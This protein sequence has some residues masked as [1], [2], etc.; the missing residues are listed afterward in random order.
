MLVMMLVIVIHAVV[1][2]LLMALI[3]VVMMVV[4]VAVMVSTRIFM[5]MFRSYCDNGD[6]N[7]ECDVYCSDVNSGKFGGMRD[8]MHQLR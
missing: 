1:V 2:L 8:P 7:S 5:L 4:V 6:D 3:L